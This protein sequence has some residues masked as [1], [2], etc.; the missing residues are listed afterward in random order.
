MAWSGVVVCK[1]S[2]VRGGHVIAFAWST[3]GHV[4]TSQ[5]SG[6]W[7]PMSRRWA[8]ESQRQSMADLDQLIWFYETIRRAICISHVDVASANPRLLSL[9][10][11]SLGSICNFYFSI[12][13]SSFRLG[14]SSFSP[15]ICNLFKNTSLRSKT[16]S[17]TLVERSHGWYWVIGNERQIRWRMKL[18]FS[19]SW[20]NKNC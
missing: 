17:R 6:I 11:A 19:S 2:C 16:T 3:T 9:P 5:S 15:R 12:V 13:R 14:A 1:R 10:A 7:N 20:K 18:S 4:R 8:K